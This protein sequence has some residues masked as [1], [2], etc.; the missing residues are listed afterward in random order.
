MNNKGK[1]QS[2]YKQGYAM[3][4]ALVSLGESIRRGGM[5]LA[6]CSVVI[7]GLV[8]L[9]DRLG[10]AVVVATVGMLLSALM[11][12]AG[13][14]LAA[15]GQI[16]LALIDT[17]VHTAPGLSDEDRAEI[18]NLGPADSAPLSPGHS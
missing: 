5:T 11:W 12:A 2:R 8:V 16:L 4:G 14:F 6:V 3:T 13:W 15:S 9:G 17:A 10:T 18:L 7:G 1:I